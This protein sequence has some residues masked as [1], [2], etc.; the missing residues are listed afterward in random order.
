MRSPIILCVAA[1]LMPCMFSQTAAHKGIET[2]D[3]DRK[4]DACTDFFQFSNGAWRA[5]HPIPASMDRWSRRWEAGEVNKDQLRVI[6]DDVSS[7]VDQPKG[8]PAQLTGDF[9]AACTDQKAIDQAGMD[10]LQPLLQKIAAIH[11]LGGLQNTLIELHAQGVQ[12]PF[13]LSGSSDLHDPQNVIADVGAGGLGLPDRDYYLKPEKRFAD[14]RSGYLSHV[15]KMFQLAG[16]SQAEARASA[17]TVMIFETALA[18]ASLDNVALRDP[19]STDHKMPFAQL[20]QLTPHFDWTAYY[21]SASLAS[22]DL[23]VQQPAFLKEVERQL[24]TTPLHD[25]KIYLRWQVLNSFADNLSQPFVDENFAFFQKQ[26]RRR[27]RIEAAHNPL[28]PADRRLA[29]G[30]AR[31][32]IR[33]ALLP[34]WGQGQ[35]SQ[36]G[37]Q[38]HRRHA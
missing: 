23:N 11:D 37:R 25:W 18:K 35:C 28:R 5:Q 29:G 38:H 3:L 10:P 32:G 15:A 2:S 17:Q 1:I 21:R 9:Y 36:V 14:A 22:A 34:A 33:Q 19:S 30:S 27:W 16:A 26:L 24:A 20:Q 7:H 8:S 4:A 12:A 6:L 31:T 13:Y